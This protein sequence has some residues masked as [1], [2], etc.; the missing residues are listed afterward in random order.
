MRSKRYEQAP[1]YQ[2][3]L[4]RLFDTA[5]GQRI[6]RGLLCSGD[7]QRTRRQSQGQIL[8]RFGL[9]QRGAVYHRELSH[10]G[11]KPVTLSDTDA[12]SMTM[13]AS[14]RKNSPG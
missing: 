12:S 1:S 9:G 7:A 13:T 8:F 5:G 4:V 3:E 6:W 10:L 2:A 14:T 11:A